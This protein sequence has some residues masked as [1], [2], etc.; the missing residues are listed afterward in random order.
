MEF[1]SI[2][3]IQNKENSYGYNRS[4]FRIVRHYDAFVIDYIK[5][6]ILVTEAGILPPIKSHDHFMIVKNLMQK[7][8]MSTR[9]SEMYFVNSDFFASLFRTARHP[10]L[11]KSI[12]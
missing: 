11:I 8:A 1:I 12:Q 9:D 3:T 5:R 6:K 10:A 7:Y 2:L 4:A